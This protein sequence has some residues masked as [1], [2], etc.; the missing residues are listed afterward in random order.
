[1]TSPFTPFSSEERRRLHKQM[2]EIYNRF[3]H[4]VAAGRQLA[5]EDVAMVARGRVWTGRQ[6]LG[7]GLVDRL[8]DFSAAVVAA[9]E[10]MRVPESRGVA[11]VQIRPPRS[12]P[13]RGPGM[14]AELGDLWT[15][16]TTLL[17]ERVLALM[18]W[19]ISLR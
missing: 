4:R 13:L 5:R 14:L 19:E 1:M 15:S 12:V 8:G 16:L 10:L 6:A 11:V 9:K 7:L 2:D 3:V 18:P 17:E